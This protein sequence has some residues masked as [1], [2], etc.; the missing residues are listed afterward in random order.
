MGLARKELHGPEAQLRPYLLAV[1]IIGV[2]TLVRLLLDPLSGADHPLLPYYGAVAVTAWYGGWWP[3]LFSLV[4]SYLV[5]DWLFIYPRNELSV[6]TLEPIHLIRC[7]TF[8]VTGVLIAAFSEAAKRS[9]HLAE[10]NARTAQER[11]R[12]LEQEITERKRAEGALAGSQGWLQL[13]LEAARM[14]TWEWDMKGDE[15]VFSPNAAEVI[16]VAPPCRI[17]NSELGR[18]WI[19]PDDLPRHQEIVAEALANCGSY[20]SQYQFRRPDNGTQVWL[21]EHA[22]V[23]CDSRGKA[24]G[25]CAIVLDITRRKQAESQI[26]QASRELERR[27]HE[28]TAELAVVN[29][30]L[31]SFSYSVSHDLRAPLRSISS[32]TQILRE[33]SEGKLDEE[34]KQMLQL[35][36]QSSRRMDELI[37]DL[38]SL[39]RVARSEMQRCPVD[40]SALVERIVTQIRRTEPQREVGFVIAPNLVVHGDERLLR[41]ALENLL[42]NAWKFTGGCAH[43]RIEFGAEQQE[44]R[45]IYF[46]RDNGAG[47]DM[48]YAGK[49]FGAFQRLHSEAEFPG[50]GIGLATVQR[51]ISRHRGQI[52]AKGAVNQGATFYFTLPDGGREPACSK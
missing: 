30:E 22:R 18:S 45:L 31:E 42:N 13:A 25:L 28:R 46:V 12:I 9:Q 36:I 3:A 49:L 4:L 41:I 35:V 19:H 48:A 29:Q 23:I 40:L 43:G 16:G 5:A 15:I 50:T 20:V 34:E 33:Q 1:L 38:L 32:F 2:T 26:E 6:L 52:W 24:T 44:G 14:V 51:I 10:Y 17:T 7:W 27:V 21:E 11:G 8:L 39:S 47:F 37:Q